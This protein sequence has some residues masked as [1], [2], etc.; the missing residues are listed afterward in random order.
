MLS[1]GRPYPYSETL[2][3]RGWG[4]GLGTNLQLEVGSSVY[5]TLDLRKAEQF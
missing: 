2:L 1:S 3:S 4:V 5:P